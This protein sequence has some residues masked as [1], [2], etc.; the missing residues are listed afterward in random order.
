MLIDW[1]TVAAQVVNFV[2]LVFLL[3]RFLYKP[4]LNAIDER[5]TRIADTVKNAEIQRSAAEAEREMYLKKNEE[6][7]AQSDDL[8]NQAREAA[9][10]EGERLLEEER[11]AADA[12]REKWQIALKSEQQRLGDDV[13]R[14]IQD[15]VFAISRQVLTD[16]T[17]M[18]LEE[19]MVEVFDRRLRMAKNSA[20][21][22]LA[23]ILRPAPESILVRSAFDLSDTQQAT[24][25]E[26]FTE[27]FASD[28]KVK[29]ESEKNLVGG[30]ELIADGR[31][32][33]WTIA[34]YLTELK[35]N[36]TFL[37]DNSPSS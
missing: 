14:R 19:R 2:I 27:V 25:R 4:V 21:D 24:L 20:S 11:Q 15:E 18:A 34:N 22:S 5:E 17:D 10:A 12:S 32:I 3:K 6:I 7:D 13:V 9:K 35:N 16:L 30:I 26:T 37:M 23:K 29:F 8:M 36:V 33:A 1:F 31:K 28:I